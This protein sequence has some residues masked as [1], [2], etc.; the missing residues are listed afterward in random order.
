MNRSVLLGTL[1][2]LLLA[3]VPMAAA[4]P[5]IPVGVNDCDGNNVCVI[6]WQEPLCAG[7]GFGLQGVAACAD[8]TTLCATLIVGF[9]RESVCGP[10]IVIG[11]SPCDKLANGC[12]KPI[13][14]VEDDRVCVGADFGQAAGACYVSYPRE[15]CLI[16]DTGGAYGRHCVPTG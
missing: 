10:G 1:L 13:V 2:L 12:P 14:I 5:D 7:V 4:K 15:A 9:N 16:V 3:S 11:P 6:V 8:A